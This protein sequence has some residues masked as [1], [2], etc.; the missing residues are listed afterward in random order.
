MVKNE[1][2]SDYLLLTSRFFSQA[3][4][5]SLFPF[6]AIIMTSYFKVGLQTVGISIG[7]FVVISRFVS[8]PLGALVDKYGGKYFIIYANLVSML[9][10]SALIFIPKDA[11]LAACF[12]VFI[13]I[14]SSA[15]QGTA[16]KSIIA[17]KLDNI[18]VRSYSQLNIASN[19]GTIVGPASIALFPNSNEIT[20]FLILTAFFHLLSLILILPM[21]NS[22]SN[23]NR[24]AKK[25]TINIKLFLK[26]ETLLFM[27]AYVI[28][29]ALL[30]MLIFCF[31]YFCL[32]YFEN[33]KLASGFFSIQALIVI[34]VMYL[35]Y[36]KY[37]AIEKFNKS[38]L[39]IIGVSIFAFSYVFL[40]LTASFI[41]PILCVFILCILITIS[42]VISAPIADSYLASLGSKNQSGIVF[43]TATL[44]EALGTGIGIFWG[45]KAL[46]IFSSEKSL[47]PR[48]W[49]V[50]GAVCLFLLLVI[51][52]LLIINSFKKPSSNLTKNP[53]NNEQA[54]SQLK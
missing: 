20:Y 53:V 34:P 11:S 5:Y 4:Y 3:A 13:R 19:L 7:I 15:S 49:S 32:H 54:K 43:S 16:Y 51:F 36:N 25:F 29:F 9:A 24:L 2:Q 21:Q 22:V 42:E 40:S 23:E 27:L 37:R 28:Q 6:L 46:E 38:L 52:I 39:F 47:L 35:C 18:S 26:T 44:F 30:Q 10:V 12:F 48:I 33:V 50:S 14:V 41:N 1:K 45:S 17:N 8:F 31:S